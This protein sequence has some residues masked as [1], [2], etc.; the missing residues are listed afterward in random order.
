MC[1][2]KKI[3]P[4]HGLDAVAKY[5]ESQPPN[6]EEFDIKINQSNVVFVMKKQDL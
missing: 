6:C 5:L 2:F 3:Q 1:F 4:L